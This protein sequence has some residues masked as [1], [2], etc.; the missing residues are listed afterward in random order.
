M[1]IQIV[2]PDGVIGAPPAQLAPA[3]R[4]LSGLRI[5][6]LDN[7]KPNAGV[8]LDRV[9][10]RLAERT[11]A[12]VGRREEKNAALPAEDQVL[13]RITKEVQVVLTGSAD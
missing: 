10:L 12:I 11:G 8:L 7:N 1:G 5:G 4:S 3:P 13:D 2:A 6:V 9:A